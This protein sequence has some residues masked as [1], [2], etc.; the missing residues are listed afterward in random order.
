[1][2]TAQRHSLVTVA[3]LPGYWARKTGGNVTA[4]VT[5]SYDGGSETAEILS[6]IAE[7]ANVTVGRDYDPTR[8]EAILRTLRPVVGRW[9]ST[10]TDQPTDTD[11]V[12]YGPPTVWPGAVLAELHEPETDARS[13]AARTI[14]L[15]FAV[16][17]AR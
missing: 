12:P 2:K 1:M 3:G 10:I 8:D 11:L 14:E 16:G 5:R 9:R 15:V 7:P 4:D 17:R 6:G 13:G